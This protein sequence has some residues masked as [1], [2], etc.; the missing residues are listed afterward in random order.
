MNAIASGALRHARMPNNSAVSITRGADS[1]TTELVDISATGVMVRRPNE[2]RGRVGD[3][4]VLD[5]LVG[6][7]TNIHV[8]ATAARVTQWHIGFAY[9]RIPQDNEALLWDLLGQYAD[10][11]ESIR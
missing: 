9:E 10:Q 1:W 6:P 7:D 8:E 2:W 11:T 5:M 3:R 4:Y